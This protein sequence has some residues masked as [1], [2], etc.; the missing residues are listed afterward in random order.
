MQDLTNQA[1]NITNK[2]FFFFLVVLGFELRAYT[3]S[4]STS[5]FCDGLFSKIETH[6]L[7]AQL[8][9]NCDPPDLCLLTS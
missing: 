4:H 1:S 2:S 3:L 5:P 8:A 7:F 6:K 9:S